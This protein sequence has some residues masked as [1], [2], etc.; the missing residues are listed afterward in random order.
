MRESAC[1]GRLLS[2]GPWPPCP[3]HRR[4]GSC[5]LP[6]RVR[7]FIWFCSLPRKCL[8]AKKQRCWPRFRPQ[9]SSLR[10]PDG[11]MQESRDTVPYDELQ[12]SPRRGRRTRGGRRTA[13]Q[14]GRAAEFL[15]GVLTGLLCPRLHRPTPGL[16]RTTVTAQLTSLLASLTSRRPP[17]RTRAASHGLRWSDRRSQLTWDR[18]TSCAGE[19]G[20]AA[21]GRWRT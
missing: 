3:G 18:Y 21:L 11:Q 6:G 7:L 14:A 10:R 20:Q 12:S 13:R 2:V 4:E 16:C 19:R 17:Q 9:R 1:S 5:S 15:S 8:L